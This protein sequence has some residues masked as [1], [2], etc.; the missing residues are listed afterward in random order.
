MATISLDELRQGVETK[1]GDYT[2]ALNDEENCR[3]RNAMRLSKT[4]R[5]EL[6]QLQ[7]RFDKVSKEED[8][9]EGDENR[10]SDD[11]I[12][13]EIVAILFDQIRLLAESKSSANKLLKAVGEDS[14]M[15]MYLIG[16]Y[17]KVAMPGEASPSQS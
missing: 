15:L 10:R 5:R 12:E 14:A 2:I 8:L 7:K 3:L 9:P 17:M 16:E 11:E 4:E 13:D 6:R 1:F